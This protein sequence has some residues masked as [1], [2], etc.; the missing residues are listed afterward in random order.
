MNQNAFQATVPILEE[1]ADEAD[2]IFEGADSKKLHELLLTLKGKL[3]DDYGVSA[4]LVIEVVD[5]RRESS[6]PMLRTG[7]S[8]ASGETYRTYSD[9]TSQRYLVDSE[10]EVVPHDRCPKCWGIWMFKLEHSICVECHA[11]MGNEV[12]L[13]IDDDR[14]PNCIDGK[15]TSSNP[16]CDNCEFEV[17]PNYVH[18]G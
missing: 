13:L 12:K 18:W 6:M 3:G 9:A 7:I 5:Q 10:I 1:V 2:R 4:E 8:A 16:I 14:C 11:E 15:I 17:D